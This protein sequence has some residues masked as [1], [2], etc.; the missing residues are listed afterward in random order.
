MVATIIEFDALWQTIWSAA[1]AGIG[2]TLVFSLAVL[3]VTRS[4]DLRRAG[5]GATSAL[6]GLL[7]LLGGAATIG[8]IAYGIILITKK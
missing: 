3:G 8:A 6:Y 5:S 2:V 1:L 7:A 4:S